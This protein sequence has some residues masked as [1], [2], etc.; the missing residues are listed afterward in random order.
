MRKQERDEE[1][2]QIKRTIQVKRRE[3]ERARE[4]AEKE[5]ARQITDQQRIINEIIDQIELVQA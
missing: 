2:Q 4:F 3:E 1:T 5:V